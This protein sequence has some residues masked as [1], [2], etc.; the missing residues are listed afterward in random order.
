MKQLDDLEKKAE[1]AIEETVNALKVAEPEQQELS[2]TE[3]ILQREFEIR[4]KKSTGEYR[5]N[6][7]MILTKRFN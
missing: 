6:F 2:E 5:S 7:R 3:K 4:Y 1:H